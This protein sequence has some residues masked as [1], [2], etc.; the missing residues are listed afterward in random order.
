M[1]NEHDV[2]MLKLIIR[3][4]GK[5]IDIS[6]WECPFHDLNRRKSTCTAVKCTDDETVNKCRE[7]LKKDQIEKEIDNILNKE[8]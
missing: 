5:C 6:C 1:L 4:K 3:Q 7:K 2:A 8:F